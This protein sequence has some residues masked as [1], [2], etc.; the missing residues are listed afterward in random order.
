M[1]AVP[2][3]QALELVSGFES[4]D[5]HDASSASSYHSDVQPDSPDHAPL[6]AGLPVGDGSSLSKTDSSTTLHLPDG[7]RGGFESDDGSVVDD[8][9]DGGDMD[10]SLEP[11]AQIYESKNKNPLAYMF[12]GPLFPRPLVLPPS[13]FEQPEFTTPVKPKTQ[14]RLKADPQSSTK[15]P[16]SAVC[17]DVTSEK[18]TDAKLVESKRTKGRRVSPSGTPSAPLYRPKLICDRPFTGTAMRNRWGR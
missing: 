3:V 2:S 11:D 5:D 13:D 7:S 1:A 18:M 17:F 12:D 10:M 8:D 6:Q 16:L 9:S 15:H 14:R 4:P